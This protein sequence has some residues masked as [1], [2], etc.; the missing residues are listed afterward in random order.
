MKTYLIQRC[1]FTDS[2]IKQGIDSILSLDY[3]G[4]AEFEFGAL[5]KSLKHIRDH[6]K[7]YVYN[8]FMI[9]GKAISVFCNV[10]VI[11]EVN[12]YLIKLSESK[13]TLHEHSDFDNYINPSSYEVEWQKEYG[14]KTDCWW[15]IDNHLF[16]WKEDNNFRNKFK[17]LINVKS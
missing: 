5:P 4:A 11:T 13:M 12:K 7:E 10:E 2:L 16:F 3:M 17:I 6:I 1:T 8:T 9:K 15:D 14:H